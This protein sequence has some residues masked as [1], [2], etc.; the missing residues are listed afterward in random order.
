MKR[1]GNENK[2]EPSEDFGTVNGTGRGFEAQNP[3][4]YTMMKIVV[5]MMTMMMMIFTT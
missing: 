4:S 1:V 2:D 3:A 5:G